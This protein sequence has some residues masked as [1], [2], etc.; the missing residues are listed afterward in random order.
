MTSKRLKKNK[1][2]IFEQE[3]IRQPYIK[4]LLQN[5]FKEYKGHRVVEDSDENKKC[6]DIHVTTK[7]GGLI[8]IEVK[9]RRSRVK[10]LDEKDISIE[11]YKAWPR[12]RGWALREDCDQTDYL[13]EIWVRDGDNPRSEPARVIW[14][15]WQEFVSMVQKN[16]KDWMADEENMHVATDNYPHKGAVKYRYRYPLDELCGNVEG[17]EVLHWVWPGMDYSGLNKNV[18]KVGKAK[19]IPGR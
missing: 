17:V 7:G 1:D 13:L 4:G 9:F 10:Y 5:K 2:W 15:P 18:Q 3:A 12:I 11:L 16:Y 19:Y 14:A 8:V 6:Q